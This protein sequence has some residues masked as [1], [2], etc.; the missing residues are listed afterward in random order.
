MSKKYLNASLFVWL[1]TAIA[2]LPHSA[3]AFD[4]LDKL[5]NIGSNNGP[6]ESVDKIGLSNVIGAV[7]QGAL[8][9][10]GTIFLILML[11]AGYNWMTAR[12]EEEKVTKAKD[13]LTRAIIGIIIVIGSYAIWAFIFSALF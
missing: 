13:T 9:L 2:S 5:Q 1:M 4:A 12:G 6:Y 11:Y 8:G 7:V 3:W 10:I